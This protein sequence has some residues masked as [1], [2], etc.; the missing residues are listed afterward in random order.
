MSDVNADL[1]PP[2]EQPTPNRRGPMSWAARIFGLFV[3][4]ATAAVLVGQIW[5]AFQ[6]EG[7]PLNT[8]NEQGKY[9]KDIAKLNIWVFGVAGLILIGVISAIL[10]IAWKYRERPDADPTSSPKQIEGNT[11]LEITWTAIPA[12]IL[13]G[14]AFGTVVTIQELQPDP[15]E[16]VNCQP[17]ECPV[18]VEVFAQQWWWGYRYDLS[19]DGRGNGSFDDPEDIVTASELV[20][21]VKRD[22][23]LHIT[24]NDVIH[25][26]WIP[27]LNGKK[28]AV[29]G[30]YND[31]KL[32]AD[33][34]G[35]YLGT[36]TEFCGL[37]HA[38]MRM[39]VRAVSADEYQQ[40]LD[41]QRKPALKPDPSNVLA[42]EGEKLFAS[43]RCANCH[44]IRGLTDDKVSGPDGAKSQ[45]VSG[46]APDLTHFAS[47]G[48]FAGGIYNSRYP[49][50]EGNHQ[51]FGATCTEADLASCGDPRNLS[52][53]GNPDNPPYRPWLEQWLRDPTSLKPMAPQESQNP[54]AGGR[55]RGMPN[56]GLSEQQ[57]DQL[58]AYL[59]TL[60]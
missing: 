43:Q 2:G 45:L 38:N 24:S 28:D 47:R 40:W 18:Q 22:V 15:A 36:C 59:L 51:P 54:E 19:N 57:I 60:K 34:P 37:S 3:C 35:T 7:R 6:N 48:V 41:N 52:L 10:F 29:P 42:V 46:V 31:W 21:P 23:F 44:L 14:L 53:P 11:P 20:I 13:V 55:V 39:L 32:Q 30:Q 1:L 58:V 33:Q 49:N 8:L 56:L 27:E 26:F 16:A 17:A 12:A 25:S 50:K 9:A 5:D 4:A